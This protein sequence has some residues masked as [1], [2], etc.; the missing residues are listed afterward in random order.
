[1][2]IRYNVL[3]GALAL[4]AVGLSGCKDGLGKYDNSWLLDNDETMTLEASATSIKLDV[5][6]LDE[7]A[8][9]F[10][11]TPAREMSDE[12]VLSYVTM[13][14]MKTNEFNSSSVVRTLEDD[15]VYEKSYTNLE[16]QNLIVDKWGKSISEVSTLSFKVI[17]KWEGGSK[18]VM[19]E[20][21]TVDV[22]IQPYRPI[23][24]DA[25]KVFLDGEAVKGVRPS[26]NYTM[27]KTPENEFIYAGEF[28][29]KAG[30]MTIPIQYDGLTRYI[31]PDTKQS[32]DVPDNDPVD[33]VLT[34]TEEYA[35]TVM[36]IPEGGEEADLPAWNLPSEGFW[37]VIIDMENKTVKFF[38]P[39]NRLE[40]LTVSFYY[41]NETTGWLL[42][43]TLDKK[44]YYVN[45]MTG[46]DGW[47]G[48]PFEFI[49]SQIDPQILICNLGKITISQD[50]DYTDSNGEKKKRA[51][52]CI[53]TGQDIGNGYT[54]VESGTGT[55]END[56]TVTTGM[57]FVSK[58][59]GFNPGAEDTPI[60]MNKPIPMEISISNKR[61]VSNDS[62]ITISKIT[63]NL[64]EST[65]RFD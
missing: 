8:L 59:L 13:L 55:G 45:S 26:S 64:R 14:D 31:V 21:R 54:V 52:F 65:I 7:D 35:A 43:Q 27:T 17:A 23:T 58:T 50:G 44:T 18:Y 6:A 40:P 15:G 60:V 38:S 63:I 51:Q 36:D 37:R 1:M 11:W 39:K 53:K 19:P 41:G 20:V 9:T 56:P 42:K 10:T 46:W 30:R 33:G 25:D 29:M 32:V 2:N 5:N 12:Y 34:G 3:F 4:A 22:D 28:L 62:A 48:K 16:L 47:K 24:F 61:W 49:V 57:K